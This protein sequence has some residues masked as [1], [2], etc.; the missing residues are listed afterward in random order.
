[1]PKLI[2]EITTDNAAFH[3]DGHNTGQECARILRNLAA[4]VE[5]GGDLSGYAAT[6]RDTNGN[7]VGKATLEE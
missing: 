7:T 5:H 1:M 4:R 3:E 2:I 6:L